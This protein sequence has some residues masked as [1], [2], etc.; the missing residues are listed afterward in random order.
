MSRVTLGRFLLD[1]PS[2]AIELES[3]YSMRSR[4]KKQGK[5]D[6]FPFLVSRERTRGLLVDL[7]AYNEFA[8]EQGRPLFNFQ[9]RGQR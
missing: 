8:R 7:D 5:P 3:I 6:P 9:G 4:A 2:F 1:H